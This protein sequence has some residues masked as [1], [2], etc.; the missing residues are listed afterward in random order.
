MKMVISEDEI[1]SESIRTKKQ[2]LVRLLTCYI[3]N[4]IFTDPVNITECLHIC[5]CVVF[6]SIYIC[7]LFVC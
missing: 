6:F 2:V 4:N 1:E 5:E 3:C 7:M